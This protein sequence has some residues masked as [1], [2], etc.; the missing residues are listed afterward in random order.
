MNPLARVGAHSLTHA[1]ARSGAATP[2]PRGSRPPIDRERARVDS[3]W[4]FSVRPPLLR[5]SLLTV[6]S[7]P[8]VSSHRSVAVDAIEKG[9][10]LGYGLIDLERNLGV[11]IELREHLNQGAILVDGDTVLACGR[12]DAFGHVPLAARDDTWRAIDTTLVVEG[13]GAQR[14]TRHHDTTRGSDADVENGTARQRRLRRLVGRNQRVGID[15]DADGDV[16]E[17]DGA[18][19][20]VERGQS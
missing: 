9:E 15:L 3:L 14:V 5:F 6:P 10:H 16:A 8:S 12:E 1:L 18:Q 11:D 4:V 19:A 17:T 7:V 13:G 20:G 2:R